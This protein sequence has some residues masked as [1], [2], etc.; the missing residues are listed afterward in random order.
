MDLNFRP[1]NAEEIEVR[2]GSIG[3]KGVTLLLYKDARVDMRL[4]DEVVGP[5][6][7]KREHS[8]DNANCTV[9]IWDED[10]KE[11]VSKE[12]TGTQ[13]FTEAEKG[14]ASDSFK[15]A[16]FNWGIGRELYS[17]PFTWVACPTQKKHDGR[18]YELVERNQFAGCYVKDIGYDDNRNI[19]TLVICNKA[20]NPI[21]STHGDAVPVSTKES[22]DN[23]KEE[24]KTRIKQLAELKS[25]TIEQICEKGRVDSLDDMEVQRLKNVIDWLAGE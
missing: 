16:C 12:D 8:R 11:W 21:F 3:P 2:V 7:W 1:L 15:R 20:G 24:L 5:F 6:N 14:L 9:S 22:D 19:V 25:M 13:S 10:K 18:G 4:L 17:S 23:I